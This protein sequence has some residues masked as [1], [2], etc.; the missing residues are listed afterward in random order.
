MVR[1]KLGLYHKIHEVADGEVTYRDISIEGPRGIIRTSPL[2]EVE[3]CTIDPIT[4]ECQ[5]IDLTCGVLE[6]NAIDWECVFGPGSL[7]EVNERGGAMLTCPTGTKFE[8]CSRFVVPKEEER[9]EVIVQD[10]PERFH[11]KK[12]EAY[13]FKYSFR[14]KEGM[15]VATYSTRLGQLKG[16]SNGFLLEGDPMMQIAATNDGIN[17]RFSNLEDE[18]INGI[19]N[20]LSWEDATG[21]WVHVQIRT[22]F[23]KSMQVDFSGAVEG[24]AIWPSSY[25]PVAWQ[26]DADMMNFRLGL[27]H[28]KN[29]VG[30][31]EVEYKNISIEGPNG[32]IR[33]SDLGVNDHGDP[34]GILYKSC[35]KDTA[36]DRVLEN[37]YRNT[38]MTIEA[39]KLRDGTRRPQ[40]SIILSRAM[41]AEY[42]AGEEYFGT[43]YGNECWCGWSH[44]EDVERHGSGTCDYPCLGD[45]DQ[46]C[47]GWYS[48][49][50]YQ[51]GGSP[52]A[53]IPEGSKY[54]GCYADRRFERALSYK[55]AS[56]NDMTHEWCYDFC[57][58]F[59]AKYF[60]IQWGR[61]CFCGEDDED[62]AVYGTSLCDMPCSGNPG[63]TCGSSLALNVFMI[64]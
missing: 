45:E 34:E 18:W 53:D 35:V 62:Y 15:R 47:G 61:E 41:C 9:A 25:T 23:G 57:K 10:G 58:E 51:Y 3:T 63:L 56:S 50:L 32:V 30:D 1:M 6:G 13:V 8:P 60:G 38:E 54:L 12:G 46:T 59:N 26:D 64:Y 55:L 16:S 27:Y 5:K 4:G 19:D 21:D 40:I 29:E 14:A 31:G 42:C 39:S 24:T 17:V 7:A 37:L 36:D 43:Q 11:F 2:T 52:G 33:T 20:F 22:T 44:G 48:M 49:S 28:K